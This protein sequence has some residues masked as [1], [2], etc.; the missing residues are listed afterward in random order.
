MTSVGNTADFV[1]SDA[2]VASGDDASDFKAAVIQ[3]LLAAWSVA[4]SG[5]IQL[6][7]QVSIQLYEECFVVPSTLITPSFQP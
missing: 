4:D 7:C 6:Y 3:S 2:V 1:V 5:T